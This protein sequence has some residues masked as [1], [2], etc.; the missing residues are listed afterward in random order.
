MWSLEQVL[1]SR[2]AAEFCTY[3]SFFKDFVCGTIEDTV[4]VV[5]PGCYKCMNECFCSSG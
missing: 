2:R 3:C 1:V 5:K 4:A